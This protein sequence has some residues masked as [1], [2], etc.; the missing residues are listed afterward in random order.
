MASHES[1]LPI[2][3]AIAANVLIASAKFV[4]AAFT[5]SSAMISEGIHSLVDAG[6]GGL[7][8]VGIRLSRRPAD[9]EHPFGHGKELYVWSLVVAVLVFAVGAGMSFYEGILHWVHPS[10]LANLSWSFGVL[11]AAT[12]FEAVSWVIALRRFQSVRGERGLWKTL[13]DTKDPS[14]IAVFLEDTAALLGLVI[15]AGGMALSHWT[16]HHAW[17]GVASI[18]IGLLLGVVATILASVSRALLLGQAMDKETVRRLRRVVLEDPSVQSARLPLTMHMGPDDVLVNLTV[19]FKP[20]VTM[21]ELPEAITRLERRIRAEEPG[22]RRIFIE[23]E[24]LTPGREVPTR[25]GPRGE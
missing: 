23:A 25:D 24:S 18:L 12:V 8:L 14:A 13:F 7:L 20:H 19:A 15:A 1:I 6:N 22:V 10:S 16:G 2:V 3:A 11:G 21:A 9:D 17:D 4:A 5:G